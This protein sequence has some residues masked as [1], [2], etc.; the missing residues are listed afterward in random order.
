MYWNNIS[1]DPQG[2][3]LGLVAD[4]RLEI[5]HCFP[6]PRLGRGSTK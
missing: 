6:F 2:A 4:T 1:M 3:L 5:T